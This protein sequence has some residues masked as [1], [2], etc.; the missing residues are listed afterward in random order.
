MHSSENIYNVVMIFFLQWI[1]PFCAAGIS[2]YLVTLFVFFVL[3]RYGIVDKPEL[4]PHE[5]G[6]GPLPY[7]GGIVLI[8]NLLLW[9]PWILQSVAE[10]D[11]KKAA[12][13]LLA[14]LITSLVMAWD[15]QRRT[16][17]P[18]FR[19]LFQVGL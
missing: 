19:L 17:S 13:V 10:S 5:K 16:L 9:S 4:Y 18:I 8:L 14:G 2:M 7:P 12:Y 3:K 6:R 15:D 1:L 11:M